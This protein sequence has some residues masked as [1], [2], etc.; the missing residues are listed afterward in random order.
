[1][2]IRKRLQAKDVQVLRKLLLDGLTSNE[3]AKELGVSIATVSNYRAYFKKNGDVFPNNQ[4]RKPK[5]TVVKEDS[6]TQIVKSNNQF[7]DTYKYNINGLQVTFSDK[8]KALLIGKKGMIVE[9]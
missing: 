8:P 3:A 7:S 4:G 1:M 5:R 6:S 9:Y 2:T